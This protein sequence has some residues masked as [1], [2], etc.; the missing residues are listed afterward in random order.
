MSSTMPSPA[1]TANAPAAPAAASA[2]SREGWFEEIVREHTA[3][4]F[5]VALRV[6]GDPAIAEDVVQESL[7]SIWRQARTYD[8]QRGSVRTWLL[9]V[10]RNR[11]ID[12]VRAERSRPTSGAIDLDA[13][14]DLRSGV[15]VWTDVSAG[16]DR[17]TI[18]Q[19]LLRLPREQRLAIELAYFG[20]LTQA[21]I[22]LRTGVPLGTVK[23]RM[24]LGLTR[25][26]GDLWSTEAA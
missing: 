3:L 19:A 24:R 17:E 6:V 7:L 15:D 25:L 20:G 13:L 9:A 22:A 11:A 8:R 10:V 21:E 2:P 23:G 4:A 1:L 26:R 5:T 18:Q 14:V 16:L 12:R